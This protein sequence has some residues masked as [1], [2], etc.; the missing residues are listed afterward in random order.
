MG[1]KKT[2][3]AR[4]YEIFTRLKGSSNPWKHDCYTTEY[5]FLSIDFYLIKC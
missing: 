5:E 3:E 4:E 1:V 2:I